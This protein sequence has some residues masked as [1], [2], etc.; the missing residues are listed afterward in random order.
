MAKPKKTVAAPAQTA[1]QIDMATLKIIVE[2]TKANSA[3]YVPEA[4]SKPLV[5]AGLVVINTDYKDPQGNI[6]TR[7]TDAGIAKLEVPAAPAWGAPQVQPM[8]AS[9]AIV[10]GFKLETG[11]AVPAA[12][13]GFGAGNGGQG[14]KSIYPFA[15]MQV[16]QSF[17]V[18]PTEAMPDPA[19][20]L[21]STVSSATLRYS[22]PVFNADG[23]PKMVE[24]MIAQ[25]DAEGNIMKD[26]TGK[27][28]RQ[29]AQVQE[30]KQTR[31]FV[32]RGVEENG[33]KGARIWRTS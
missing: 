10:G 8:Q 20:T 23:T 6:A 13:R 31:K 28:L 5:D 33:V 26:G 14:R 24:T 32:I 16:G 18:A 27:I 30:K 12:K 4:V 29:K 21:G 2:A 19:K 25:R 1:P 9:A 7:A 15:D 22:E 17:F 11:V 3:A